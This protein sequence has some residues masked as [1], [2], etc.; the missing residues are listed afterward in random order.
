MRIYSFG[1][2]SG[3]AVEAFGSHGLTVAGILG[4]SGETH[5]VCMH[6]E[7]GGEVGRHEAVSEQLFLVVQGEGWVSGQ[8]GAKT[9]IGPGQA[10]YWEKGE[11]HAS[12]SAGGMTAVVVEGE[13]FELRLKEIAR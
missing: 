8:D 7:A 1:R 13:G 10:A 12:G 2:E 6:I 5:M 11:H 3:R 4:G 9:P